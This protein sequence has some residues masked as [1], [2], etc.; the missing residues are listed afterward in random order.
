[1]NSQHDLLSAVRDDRQS[2]PQ[3]QIGRQR[4]CQQRRG[5]EVDPNC[6]PW[7]CVEDPSASNKPRTSSTEVVETLPRDRKIHKKA[8]TDDEDISS[9][10]ITQWRQKLKTVEKIRPQ[11]IEEELVPETTLRSV[12]RSAGFPQR[13]NTCLVCDV[14]SSSSSTR[15]EA[16]PCLVV[17]DNETGQS[18]HLVVSYGN[19]AHDHRISHTEITE[20]APKSQSDLQRVEETLSRR[21]S[22][23]ENPRGYEAMVNARKA[24]TVRQRST[25]RVSTTDLSLPLPTLSTDHTCSWRT[26]YINLSS[27]LALLRSEIRPW[28][29]EGSG[30]QDLH[31]SPEAGIEGLTIVMHMKGKDDLVINTDL[32]REGSVCSHAT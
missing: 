20:A 28:R 16:K 9:V 11:Q 12:S 7:P 30:A 22:Y 14:P 4:N 13:R 24:S 17:E 19:G 2:N 1:M 21:A 25:P 27:E 18:D 29:S 6:A 23:I 32:T 31:R 5:S 3:L 26:R 15:G 10:D 8:R